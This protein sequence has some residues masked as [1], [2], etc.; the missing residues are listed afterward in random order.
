MTDPIRLILADDQELVR[1]G[2]RMVLD[3]QPD[4]TV[5][6]EV[7]NGADAVRAAAGCLSGAHQCAPENSFRP[8]MPMTIMP[9]QAIKSIVVMR[10]VPP[11]P[12]GV[13]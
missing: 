7:G 5:V 11:F 6:T 10:F 8:T 4:M 1:L 13:Q 2:F 3:A 9:M 12:A